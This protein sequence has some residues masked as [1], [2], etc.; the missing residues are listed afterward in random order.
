MKNSIILVVLIAFISTK[1]AAQSVGLGNTDPSVFSNFRIP[2][3]NLSSLWFNTGL[4]FRS[5]KRTDAAI[6]QVFNYGSSSLNSDFTYSLSPKY[7]LLK[8]TDEKWLSLNFIIN[9][10]YGYS[11]SEQQVQDSTLYH[12]RN[13]SNQFNLN[14][15]GSYG[16]YLSPGDLFYSF[17]STISVA[18][19]NNY[20]DDNQHSQ[21]QVDKSQQYNVSFG[22]GWGKIRDVTPVV[23][24][25]RL[26]ERLKQLNL[27]NNDLSQ[28]TIEDLSE[29]FSKT[30]YYSQVHDRSDKFFWQDIEKTLSNDDISLSGINQYASSY[31]REIPN[32]IRFT[33]NEGI[34]TGLNLMIN[35]DNQFY[36]EGFEHYGPDHLFTLGNVYLNISHQLNLNSQVRF[37]LSL[38]GGPNLTKNSDINQEYI[39]NSTMGYDYEITDRIVASVSNTF[40]FTILNYDIPYGSNQSKSLSNNLSLSINYFIED[41]LSLNAFYKWNYYDSRSNQLIGTFKSAENTNNI[42]VG[43]TYYINRGFLYN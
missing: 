38:S 43:F 6:G 16:R 36:A 35:F 15:Q 30:I 33:R 40:N 28:K 39:I 21:Y 25:I 31:I 41:N 8:Q 13:K 12:N 11:Y 14:L 27:L 26:Q 34:T 4:N 29:Q 1:L 5:D 20:Y 2:E 42:V 24:A 37:S 3:T 9:D 22:I 19:H 10:N 17:G 23:S 32:E 7:Y 18:I